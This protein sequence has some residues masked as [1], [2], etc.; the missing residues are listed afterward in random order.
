MERIAYRIHTKLITWQSSKLNI[1]PELPIKWFTVLVTRSPRRQKH[2]KPKAW[3]KIFGNHTKSKIGTS[4]GDC[5]YYDYL[6]DLKAEFNLELINALIKL[7][8]DPWVCLV[9]FCTEYEKCHRRL[10]VNWLVSNYPED[11]KRHDTFSPRKRK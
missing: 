3:L 4:E 1:L 5:E 2:N 11:F 9:C 10:L 7:R 6:S 8:S